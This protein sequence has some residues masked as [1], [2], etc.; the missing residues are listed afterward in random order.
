MNHSPRT[1]SQRTSVC[2]SVTILSTVT[3]DTATNITVV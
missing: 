1:P 3:T 2:I